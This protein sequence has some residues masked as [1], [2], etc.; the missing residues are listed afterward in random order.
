M[1]IKRAQYTA[2]LFTLSMLYFFFQFSIDVHFYIISIN[3]LLPSSWVIS[4]PVDI[5]INIQKFSLKCVPILHEKVLM[6]MPYD[7]YFMNT[8]NGKVIINVCYN[9]KTWVQ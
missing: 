7:H 9:G 1:G 6:L 3:M 5:I 8:T 2:L 4:I